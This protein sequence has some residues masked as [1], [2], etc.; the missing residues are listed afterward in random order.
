MWQWHDSIWTKR[1][2]EPV[3]WMDE[4]LQPILTARV[5]KLLVL[6][7][8]TSWISGRPSIFFH[9]MSG[10]QVKNSMLVYFALTRT[11]YLVTEQVKFLN[12]LPGGQVKI[13]RFFYPWTALAF[14]RS[15]GGGSG[16]LNKNYPVWYM[17]AE[18]M[19]ISILFDNDRTIYLEEVDRWGIIVGIAWI[20][21]LGP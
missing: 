18:Q 3:M 2:A 16:L 14:C 19:I 1:R 6:V 17:I 20:F 21:I 11:S 7:P 12:Y 15:K 5:K 13:F 10:G 4:E 8:G 9:P